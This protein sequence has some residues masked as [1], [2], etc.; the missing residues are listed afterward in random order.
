MVVNYEE[1]NLVNLSNSILKYFDVKP[2]H[3]TIDSLDKLLEEKKYK[4]IV[5]FVCDGMGYYNLNEI[6]TKEDFLRNKKIM[7]L[8][9]VFPPTTAAATTT[10]LSGL[11]PS[12]HHWF[13]WDVYFKDT[14]ETI[15]VFLN[16]IKDTEQNSKIN[17]MDRDY[18]KYKNIIDLINETTS[19]KAYFA[20]PFSKENKCLNIE[21]VINRIKL[22][23]KEDSKKFIYAYIENPDKLMHKYG[24]DSK[25]VIEEVKSINKKIENLSK[26]LKDTLILVTAD[27]GLIN[28]ETILFKDSLPKMYEMLERT[29]SIEPRCVGIKLKENVKKEDFIKLYEK[30]LEKDFKLLT[31][32]EVIKNKLFGEEDSSYLRDNIGDYLLIGK[33]NKLLIDNEI[34]PDFKANHAGVTKEE[35]VVPLIIIDCK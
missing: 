31:Q 13:G 7:E 2:F 34:V 8:S 3:N 5:L 30:E 14:N 12:E 21:E 26:K 6:L 27:H 29:T 15:S 10:L 16:K 4:N 1:N 23:T 11:T 9:S 19:N 24:I 20:Y 18:M 35:L 32:E 33:T 28:T 22:L 25:E 17:V